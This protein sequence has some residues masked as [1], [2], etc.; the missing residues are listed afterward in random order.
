MTWTIDYWKIPSVGFTGCLGTVW[1]IW[2]I[3]HQLMITINIWGFLWSD[4][5]QKDLRR[6]IVQLSSVQSRDWF[7]RREDIAD[8]SVDI[9]CQ[10]FLREDAVSSSGMGRNETLW[11]Y[12]PS[13]AS[14]DHGVAHP[15]RCP[16][17][18]FWKGSVMACD[19]PQTCKFPSPDNCQKR[20]LWTHK[21]Q[22]F[23]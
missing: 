21:S 13:I 18:W 11:C 9:L 3:A 15:P 8:G 23:G 14:A 12:L 6:D 22:E 7:G 17:G 4:C 10:S 19:M 2:N 16:E 5:S 20:F 1:Q